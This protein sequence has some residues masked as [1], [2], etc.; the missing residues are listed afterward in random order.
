[1]YKESLLG[2]VEISLV[3]GE[4]DQL[5]HLHLLGRRVRAGQL[6]PDRQGPLEALPAFIITITIATQTH[7]HLRYSD[8]L[9]GRC[10]AR[11]TTPD[12]TYVMC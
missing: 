5:L 1:M 3:V 9:N 2:R 8:P 7:A 4:P 10:V 11:S 12:N 6:L